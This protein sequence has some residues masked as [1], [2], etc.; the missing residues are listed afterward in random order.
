VTTAGRDMT[1]Y[2]LGIRP[3]LSSRISRNLALTLTHTYSY[4]STPASV[5]RAGRRFQA[6]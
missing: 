5:G 2:H 3:K 4:D 1:D 6:G